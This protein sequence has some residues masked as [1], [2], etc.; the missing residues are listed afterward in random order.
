MGKRTVSIDRKDLELA[1]KP[2]SAAQHSPVHV[3]YASF[4]TNQAL[5]RLVQGCAEAWE[6]TTGTSIIVW[7]VN[8]PEIADSSWHGSNNYFRETFYI[9]NTERLLSCSTMLFEASS[10][11]IGTLCDHVSFLICMTGPISPETAHAKSTA[12][13][14]L[15]IRGKEQRK[16]VPRCGFYGVKC[17]RHSG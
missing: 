13:K 14:T 2:C 7:S 11:I 5:R 8:S 10:S 3:C 16:I 6:D 4:R 12:T 9:Y 17:G 1:H 15:S